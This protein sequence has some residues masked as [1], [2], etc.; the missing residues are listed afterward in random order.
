M[1]DANFGTDNSFTL[2]QVTSQWSAATLSW[3]NQPSASSTNEIVI[4]STTQSQLDLELDVTDMIASM[5][6]S[7]ANYGFLLKLQNEAIYTC[8]IFVGSR[9]TTYPDKVPKLEIWYHI[10]N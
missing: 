3:T 5:V 7:N 6:K 10:S 2:Q 8:R 4:A 9:N 1:V